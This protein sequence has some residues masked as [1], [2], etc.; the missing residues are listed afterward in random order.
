MNPQCARCKKTVYPMEKLNCLDQFWHKS[1]FKCEVCGM[2]LNMKN[3]K[4]YNKKPYCQA[5]YP[6]T[7]H[8]VVS[9]TP[10]NLRL[11]KQSKQQSLVEYHKD[12][13]KE[14]GH[15]TAVVDD[16]ETL[17]LKKNTENIS[18]IKYTGAS[19]EMRCGTSERGAI[20]AGVE[21][22]NPHQPGFDKYQ[23]PPMQSYSAPP[24]QRPP[25]N[26]PR[27]R[28]IY[29]YT[30]ADEDEVSFVEGDIVI[31]PNIIDEGWMEGRIERTGQFGM[32]PA[33]YVE[34]V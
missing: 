12:F 15:F 22:V 17:R 28:A 7:K 19:A 14:K 6:T 2:T 9:D 25:P 4:G 5:H 1:C 3:Y 10:E 27:Y 11:A 24:E 23:Q 30:A 20:E 21:G 16:P 26:K 13:E 33:N 18:S 31:E 8:T 29:D 34:Q 32:I